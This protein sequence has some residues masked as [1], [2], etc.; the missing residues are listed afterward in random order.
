[1]H[2]FVGGLEFLVARSRAPRCSPAGPPGSAS[3]RAPAG[4]R[5]LVDAGGRGARGRGALAAGPIR[6]G[7]Q[8]QARG[9][10]GDRDGRDRDVDRVPVPR[11]A[12]RGRQSPSRT[13]PRGPPCPRRSAAC[14]GDPG[15]PTPADP[16]SARRSGAG[17]SRGSGRRGSGSR[18]RL[19]TSVQA[20]VWCSST[21][22]WAKP[23][24]S[25]R[26]AGCPWRLG[27]SA[28][29]R[30]ATRGGSSRIRACRAASARSA[31]RPATSSR[32]SRTRRPAADRSSPNAPSN[33]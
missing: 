2:L 17:G 21:S 6:E 30:R 12:G 15:G 13:V 31:D 33:R 8:Q 10:S 14:S 18:S 9:L 16:G 4:V 5:V 7:H 28:P 25:S 27:A 11:R 20:G 26:A 29:A 3:A 1:M 19:S 32:R 24:S 23:A 22:R